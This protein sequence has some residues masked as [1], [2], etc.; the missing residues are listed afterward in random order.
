LCLFEIKKG[1]NPPKKLLYELQNLGRRANTEVL[2][3]L[4]SKYL[5]KSCA[6]FVTTPKRGRNLE[7]LLALVSLLLDFLPAIQLK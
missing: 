3:P 6:I 7:E 2:T 4:H 5:L 1:R